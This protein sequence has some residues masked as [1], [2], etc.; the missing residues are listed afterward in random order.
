MSADNY[1]LSTYHPEHG[2]IAIMAFMS[3]DTEDGEKL[4]KA[5][6]D[7]KFKRFGDDEEAMN[8]FMH[9]LENYTE[10]GEVYIHPSEVVE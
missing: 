9:A 6:A 3:D 4:R 8:E 7:D 10:Y 1:W 2:W 5:I